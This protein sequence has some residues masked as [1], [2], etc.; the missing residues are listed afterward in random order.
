M[1]R[2]A[3]FGVAIAA[4]PQG[5]GVL[6]QDIRWA[7]AAPRLRLQAGRLAAAFS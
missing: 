4:P 5:E 2:P 6:V 3:T 7:D 1:T